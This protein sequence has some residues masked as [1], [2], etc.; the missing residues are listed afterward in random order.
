VRGCGD[1]LDGRNEAYVRMDVHRNDGRDPRV[2]AARPGFGMRRI[3]VF[4]N[5]F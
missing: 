4:G 2:D 5:K 3:L 1:R